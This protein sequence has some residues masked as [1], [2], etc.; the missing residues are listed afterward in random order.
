[1]NPSKLIEERIKEL[2]DWRGPMFAKLRDIIEEADSSLTLEWKWGTAVWTS[3]G[4]LVCALGAL[5]NGVDV[6]FFEGAN[7]E[8][9]N[10][11]FNKGLEAKK[12]R[13]AEF[14]EGQEINAAIKAALKKFIVEAVKLNSKK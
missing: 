9:P 2:N 10:K 7:L 1:M 4:K 12:S 3:N 8:D 11:L 13:R 5:K 6:N 14:T